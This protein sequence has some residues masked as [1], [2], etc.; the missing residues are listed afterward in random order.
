M[1]WYLIGLFVG[2]VLTVIVF[3]IKCPMLGRI[4]VDESDPEDVKWRFVLTKEVNFSKR[5]WIVL[6]VDYRTDSS[7]K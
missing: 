7:R 5:K 1:W 2:C 6:K 4:E 3:S